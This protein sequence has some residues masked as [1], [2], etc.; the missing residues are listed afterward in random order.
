VITEDMHKAGA[1]PW[2]GMPPSEHETRDGHLS[3]VYVCEFSQRPGW[4]GVFVDQP[5]EADPDRSE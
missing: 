4:R 5:V 2:C 3:R 1:C